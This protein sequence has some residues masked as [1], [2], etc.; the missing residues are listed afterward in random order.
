MRSDRSFLGFTTLV[1]AAVL[2]ACSPKA[3]TSALPNETSLQQ[4]SLPRQSGD[5]RDGG[6]P[7]SPHIKHVVIVLQENRSFDNLFG[8]YPGADGA[9]Q[10]LTHT[11]QEVPLTESG[12]VIPVGLHNSYQAYTIEYD[13]GKMDGWDLDPVKGGRSTLYHY[14]YVNP[15]DIKPYWTMANQYVLADHTFTT[16]GSDSYIGHQDIIRGGTEINSTE[17]IMNAPTSHPWGCDAPPGTATSLLNNK[18]Q[19][20]AAKGPF[21]CYTF[22]TLRELLD[23]KGI[24]WKYYVQPIDGSFAGPIWNAFDSYSAVRNGPEWQTNLAIPTTFFTDVSAN[25]L[26]DVTWVIPDYR[27]SDHPG[28]EVDNGPS[29]VA[30]IVNAIGQSPYWNSTA[31]VITWDDWGGFY[32]HVRP[33]Q[34]DYT[35]LGFRV[36][37]LIV[38][39]YARAGYVDHKR[40]EFGSILKFVEDNWGLGRLG[41]SDTRATSIVHAFDFKQSPRAFTPIPALKS[42]DFFLR[43]PPSNHALDDE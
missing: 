5:E 25:A 13:G 26:A 28:A 37:M 17:S 19:F 35:G 7:S 41:T 1:A 27:N 30:Q 9:T 38:S 34:L 8:T 10:G 15:S 2:S 31:I 43:Q 20:L 21:P 23:A 4:R 29:W 18:R 22:S 6:A 33:P 24:S 42:K 39:P 14:Q 3:G 16:S 32:D 12:L 11:G 36:P 40:Y